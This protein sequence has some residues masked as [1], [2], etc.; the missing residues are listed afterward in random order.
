M[1]KILRLI[2]AAACLLLFSMTAAQAA[3]KVLT[4]SC[5][6]SGQGQI[7]WQQNKA[8]RYLC[9]PGGWDASAIS[10]SVAGLDCIYIG[11]EQQEIRLNEPADLQPYLGI[12]VPVRGGDGKGMGNLLIIQG[13]PVTSLMFQIDDK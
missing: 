13:S 8:G 12:R 11:E 10:L 1:K 9:L 7:I 2:L 3:E 4:A 5:P 6:A